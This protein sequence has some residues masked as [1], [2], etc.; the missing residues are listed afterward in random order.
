MPI[1]I[2]EKYFQ[3]FLFIPSA[4]I[5]KQF[6]EIYRIPADGF[7]EYRFQF[8]TLQMSEDE[9]IRVYINQDLLQRWCEQ[10]Y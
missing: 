2:F 5:G 1:V 3:L 9:N 6:S 10:L 4:S 8:S 7:F